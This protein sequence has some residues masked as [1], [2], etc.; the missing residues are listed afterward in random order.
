MN[1]NEDIPLNHATVVV[2]RAPR[3]EVRIE[4]FRVSRRHC[5][6]ALYR[7]EVLVIDLGSTNGTRI[8]GRLVGR[9]VLRPGDQLSIADCHYHLENLSRS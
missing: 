2:G 4:S 6:L 8:N 5:C 7:D 9:G 1:G 3:C